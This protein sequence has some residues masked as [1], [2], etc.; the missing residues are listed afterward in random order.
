MKTA[1]ITSGTCRISANY[2]AGLGDRGKSNLAVASSCNKAGPLAVF[3]S[4]DWELMRDI[5]RMMTSKVVFFPLEEE[6]RETFSWLRRNL[7]S[8]S[9]FAFL[10]GESYR[11]CFPREFLSYMD[12]KIDQ[13]SKEIGDAKDFLIWDTEQGEIIESLI[14]TS[15]KLESS[16]HN[17]ELENNA[18]VLYTSS[19]LN[20][21]STWLFWLGRI[22]YKRLG[23]EETYWQGSVESFPF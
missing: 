13:Y 2:K 20:R 19:V 17:L 11:H 5:D 14:I 9:S 15:R 21:L 12:R 23:I 16:F 10:N 3:Y 8:L 1:R 7:F 4:L 22:I 18:D 6:E